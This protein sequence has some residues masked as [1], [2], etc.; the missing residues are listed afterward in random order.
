M[1]RRRFRAATGRLD[2]FDPAPANDVYVVIVVVT[3]LNELDRMGILGV[4]S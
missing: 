1:I 2:D 3:V 4:V